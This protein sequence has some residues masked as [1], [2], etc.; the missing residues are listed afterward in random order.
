MARLS[1]RLRARRSKLSS[2]SRCTTSFSPR[3]SKPSRRRCDCSTTSCEKRVRLW[4][5]AM[6]WFSLANGSAG[7]RIWTT[8]WFWV[9]AS[10]PAAIS[11][12]Q[13]LRGLKDRLL[14]SEKQG[15]LLSHESKRTNRLLR[16]S[17]TSDG[18]AYAPSSSSFLP[19]TGTN[20]D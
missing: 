12:H 6:S 11:P 13:L 5:S 8:L 15:L 2:I 18:T 20:N 19:A 4:F 1:S 14:D 7:D 3:T 10:G 9:R 17:F 16:C